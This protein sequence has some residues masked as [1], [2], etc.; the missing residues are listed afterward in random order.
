M[1]LPKAGERVRAQRPGMQAWSLASGPSLLRLSFPLSLMD[2]IKA[3]FSFSNHCMG[4]MQYLGAFK[5]HWALQDN[6]VVPGNGE[7][8]RS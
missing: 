8:D 2:I 6:K 5:K 3:D 7:S 1:P 4:G